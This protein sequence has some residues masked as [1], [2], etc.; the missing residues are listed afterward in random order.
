LGLVLARRYAERGAYV[1]LCS[2]TETDL[3][4]AK[5]EIETDF[6]GVRVLTMVC[7]VGDIDQ[8]RFFIDKVNKTFGGVDVLINSASVIQVGP[9]LSMGNEDFKDALKA[10]LNGVI[11]TCEIIAP[12][13][14]EKRGGRIVNI[15]SVGGVFPT[16]HL[17]PYTAAKFGAFGFSTALGAELRKDGVK[18]VTIVPGLM[19]TGSFLNAFF[20]GQKEKEFKMFSWAGNSPLTAM[21]VESAADEIIEAADRG[22]AFKVIGWTAKLQ[23][24]FFA[25]W[26]NVTIRLLGAVDAALPGADSES[27]G[28]LAVRGREFR[29][30]LG[31]GITPWLGKRAALANNEAAGMQF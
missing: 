8:V 30:N 12:Q 9:Y 11:N 6:K 10:N 26:P 14:V 22:T 24:L 2:R 16:P 17:V 28:Q 25:L 1:A 13:M 19:R 27:R 15:T 23:R 31:H 29:F 4:C 3:E 5:K 20:K 21:S 18:V 7:D